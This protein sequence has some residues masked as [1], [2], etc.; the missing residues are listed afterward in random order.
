MK[1]KW[2]LLL[3]G[4]D[5]KINKNVLTE[6]D[7]IKYENDNRIKL[8]EDYR[9]FL[10]KVGNGIIIKNGIFDLCLGYIDISQN[11]ERLKLD[12]PFNEKYKIS[13]EY[14]NYYYE[15]KNFKGQEC[16]VA[17][18]VLKYTDEEALSI[19]EKCKYKNE[20]IDAEW[21]VFLGQNF[22]G[23]FP[24]DG[25]VPYHNGSLNILDMGFEDE[26]RLIVSGIHKGE[27]WLNYWE[28][29]F[30]PV[31]KTFYDFL[32]AYKNKDKVLKDKNGGSLWTFKE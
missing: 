11:N 13:Y 27:V 1:E 25:C 32:L 21:K 5:Y 28:T 30:E 20:C 15:G 3:E 24:K 29:E 23:Y 9:Y 22:D 7:L 16:G 17:K 12:F 6:K 2:D 10:L 8:P 31:T 19:C 18:K 4:L 14:P 26:Y